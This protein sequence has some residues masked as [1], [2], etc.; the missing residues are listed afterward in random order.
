MGWSASN[1]NFSFTI[2]TETKK[3]QNHAPPPTQKNCISKRRNQTTN[4]F[5]FSSILLPWLQSQE[6]T[7]TFLLLLFSMFYSHKRTNNRTREHFFHLHKKFAP[8]VF[9]FETLILAWTMESIFRWCDCLMISSNHNFYAQV[10]QT[11]SS[12]MKALP[13]WSCVVDTHNAQV[14]RNYCTTEHFHCFSSSVSRD[15]NYLCWQTH[16]WKYFYSFW[17]WL[18]MKNYENIFKRKISIDIFFVPANNQQA[19]SVQTEQTFFV[20]DN[21]NFDVIFVQKLTMTFS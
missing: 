15:F 21:L 5:S 20:S 14:N 11:F 9:H 7:A 17:F 1:W 2:K 8:I 10:F 4:F 12:V 19:I 13:W 16:K 6:K 3:Q 18:L